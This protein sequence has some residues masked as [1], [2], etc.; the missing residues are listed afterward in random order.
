MDNSKMFQMQVVLGD[1]IF[2]K[3]CRLVMATG[4]RLLIA[5]VKRIQKLQITGIYRDIHGYS[6]LYPVITITTVF[7]FNNIDLCCIFY[8]CNN[9]YMGHEP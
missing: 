6:Q 1:R 5:V 9:P 2:P 4:D 7:F 3:A 8:A